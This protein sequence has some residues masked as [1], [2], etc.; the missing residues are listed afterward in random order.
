MP[1]ALLEV[2]FITNEEELRNMLS[3]SWQTKVATGVANG[4][5][6]TWSEITVP[7]N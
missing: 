5:I 7:V 3:D 2:G 1:A 4:I 6:K